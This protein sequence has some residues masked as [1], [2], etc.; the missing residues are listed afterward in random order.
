MRRLTVICLTALATVALMAGGVAAVFTVRSTPDGY[1]LL[2]SKQ[3][4]ECDEGGPCMV[5]SDREFKAI[6][7]AILLQMRA[8]APQQQR[9]DK[10]S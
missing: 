5:L 7:A 1:L 4:K 2:H 9:W 6:V 10:T 3:A 8:A